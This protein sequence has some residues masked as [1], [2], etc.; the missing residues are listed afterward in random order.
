MSWFGFSLMWR[1]TMTTATIIKHTFNCGGGYSVRLSP[2]S[3]QRAC[4]HRQA[5]CWS[6]DS[7]HLHR[8]ARGVTG[9]PR[10]AWGKKH[11]SPPSQWR[12]SSYKATPNSTTV[13]YGPFSFKPPQEVQLIYL[14]LIISKRFTFNLL[15]LEWS[16]EKWGRLHSKYCPRHL[17]SI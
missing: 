3:W 10:E 4:W 13:F 2:S 6:W 1:D 9:L 15:F 14:L 5:W 17:Y 12:T 11:Q 8:Q 16:T 7:F